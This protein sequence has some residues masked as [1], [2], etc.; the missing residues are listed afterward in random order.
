MQMSTHGLI[1]KLAMQ[2]SAILIIR[3]SSSSPLGQIERA[4]DSLLTCLTGEWD[5]TCVDAPESSFAAFVVW[6]SSDCDDAK[7][8]LRLSDLHGGERLLLNLPSPR[9][10]EERTGGWCIARDSTARSEPATDTATRRRLILTP[11]PSL[12]RSRRM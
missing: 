1:A 8:K 9:E 11:I 10:K 6:D 2:G 5:P 4:A 12:L 3:L 7:K